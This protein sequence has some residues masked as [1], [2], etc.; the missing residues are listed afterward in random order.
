MHPGRV[1]GDMETRNR[2]RMQEDW[3]D[4]E[5]GEGRKA[6]PPLLPSSLSSLLTVITDFIGRYTGTRGYDKATVPVI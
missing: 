1:K 5:T 4:K 3:T 2:D 6:L